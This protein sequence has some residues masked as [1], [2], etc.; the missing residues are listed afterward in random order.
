[1]SD[2]D[3]DD[4]D[5][6]GDNNDDYED[7]GGGGDNDEDYEDGGGGGDNDEDDGGYDNNDD[8]EDGGGGDDNNNDGD[9]DKKR[10]RQQIR[11]RSF[12]PAVH[13]WPWARHSSKAACT[14]IWSHKQTRANEMHS[15]HDFGLAGG[16]IASTWV[17]VRHPTTTPSIF[18]VSF[19][20][21]FTLSNNHPSIFST[22]PSIHHSIHQPF[23][24]NPPIHL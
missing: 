6:G 10:W 12:L 15:I 11:E 14:T 5:D 2:G 23:H 7:G 20:F 1:M 22:I 16:C 18:P 24:S 21:P 4:E 9:D 19:K 17:I 8:N 13:T 3:N